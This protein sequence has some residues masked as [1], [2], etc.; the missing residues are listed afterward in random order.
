[1]NEQAEARTGQAS[2][3]NV[4]RVV[5]G[6]FLEMYDFMVYGFY[7]S[8]IAKAMFP[9]QNEFVSLMLSLAT[10]GMGFLMR[11]LGAIVLG[12]YM[13]R[14]GRRAGLI[15]TLTLMSIGVLMIAVTPTY[16][17]IGAA[18]PI[19]VI[20]G[21]LLQGFSAGAESGGVSVY[22]SEVA[23]PGRRGFYVS[24]QSASQQISV[25]LAA[26]LGVALRFTLSNEQME[27]WGWRIPFLLG[28]SI[29]PVLFWIRRSVAESHVFKAQ[30][31]QST[32]EI[33]GSLAHNWRIILWS[34]MLV[35]LTSIMFYLITAYTPTFGRAE[36]GLKPIDTFYVTTCVAITTFVMIPL[37]AALSDRIG[38]KPLL[39]GASL[40]IAMVAWPAMTWLVA[41]PSFMSLLMVE[42]GFAFLY[43]AYQAALVVTL[44][45]IIPANVRGTGFSLAYSLSQAIFGGF[46][47]AICTA[48]IHLTGNKAMPGVWLALGAL[49][50]LLATLVIVRHEREPADDVSASA[51]S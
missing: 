5:S 11:P 23:P 19:L 21:R 50:A 9:S 51:V 31:P 28:C 22:L 25:L 17:S 14:N 1:M 33:F 35:S 43:A 30:K 16:A 4:V 6:N 29:V 18:A 20:V 42:V 2:A 10:F 13:D 47:P 40:T 48:L 39:L 34:T 12:S 46:T 45:E 41:A 37:M 27:A 8:A 32:G 24:W 44:T 36:L 49:F 3:R 38:R 15:L 26:V 7:A